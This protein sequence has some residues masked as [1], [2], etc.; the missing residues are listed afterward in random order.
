MYKHS[1][2]TIDPRDKNLVTYS[3][4]SKIFIVEAS[5]LKA[6]GI[7]PESHRYTIGGQKWVIFLWSEKYQLHICYRHQRQV[8]ENG[9][10][11]ADVFVPYFS[12]ITGGNSTKAHKDSLGTELHI[13]N[14]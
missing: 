2:N 5:S 12:I 14:D 9:E 1:E 3:K 8:R 7:T 13:L 4:S 10:L 11:I 6:A